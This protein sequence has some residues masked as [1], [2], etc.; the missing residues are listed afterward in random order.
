MTERKDRFVHCR[1]SEDDYNRFHANAEAMELAPSQYLHYLL[2]IPVGDATKYSVVAID[3]GAME[4]ARSELVRW[5]HHY[6]QAVHALNT[7]AFY[8]RRGGGDI[9]YFTEQMER[10]N[11]ELK[12][13]EGGEQEL[14]RE[15]QQLR[16]ATLV[17]G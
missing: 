15:L 10:A 12:A 7:I 9:A 8:V 13:V 14:R 16:N 11:A 5:G 3:A 6:N 2:R 17:E 4:R 1:L